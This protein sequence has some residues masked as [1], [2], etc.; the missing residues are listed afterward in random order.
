MQNFVTF[1]EYKVGFKRL[2]SKGCLMSKLMKTNIMIGVALMLGVN[3]IAQEVDDMYFRSKD[4]EKQM[5]SVNTKAAQKETYSSNYDSFKKKNFDETTMLDEY[6]NP[7]DS[8]SAR[9]INPEYVAR[10]SSEQATADEQNYFVEG[11]ASQ[12]ARNQYTS[13][14]NSYYSNNWNNTMV[15]PGYYG[16]SYYNSFYSPYYGYNN[17]WGNPYWCGSGFNS[18]WSMSMNYMWGNMG[19]SGWNMGL[20]YTW[21][22]PYYGSM[23]GPSWSWG[24]SWGMW[25]PWYSRPVYVVVDGDG[26]RANYGKRQTTGTSGASNY[27]STRPSTRQ[28]SPTVSTNPL[29]RERTS[30]SDDYYVRPSRRTYSST[31]SSYGTSNTYNSGSRSYNSSGNTNTRSYNNTSRSYN[32]SN[33]SSGYSSPSRSYSGGSMSAPSRSSSGSSGSSG[34][35]RGNN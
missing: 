24:S 12:A 30:T 27:V 11:Y 15:A 2:V 14:Y 10:S 32:G 20:G 3:A 29:G 31:N 5:A 6:N 33:Q 26:N 1:S 23:W 28:T 34:S 13:G 35:R 7:T 18:G 8:Y 9:N 21:G 22:N 4:R 17:P 16:P 19:Y 25:N